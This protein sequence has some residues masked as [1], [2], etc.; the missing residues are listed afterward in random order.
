[1]AIA[2]ALALTPAAP[3]TVGLA[4]WSRQLHYNQ[5]ALLVVHHGDVCD[6]SD[7]ECISLE[8][9]Q[10]SLYGFRQL[11]CS[12]EQINLPINSTQPLVIAQRSSDLHWL[13]Y[14]LQADTLLFEDPSY[15]AA[16]SFWSA[17]GLATPTLVDPFQA[18]DHLWPTASSLGVD[19]LFDLLTLNPVAL[20]GLAVFVLLGLLALKLLVAWIWG[21]TG[22]RPAIKPDRSSYQSG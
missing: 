2:L 12:L 9:K 21:C 19:L 7:K 11:P 18:H 16:L 22:G 4:E 17:R 6:G 8:P 20:A 10:Q 3:A 15:Q 14:D 1:M 13:V 5:F